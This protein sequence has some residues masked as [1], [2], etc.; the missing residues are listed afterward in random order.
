MENELDDFEV[1]RERPQFLKILC[2]LTFIGSGW[3]ICSGLFSYFNADNSA[4]IMVEVKIK[5]STNV[6][7]DSSRKHKPPVFVQEILRNAQKALTPDNLRKISISKILTG[8]FCLSGALLMWNL[9]RQG[10]YLYILGVAIEIF[11]PFYLFG[12]NSYVI[13][14]SIFIA[15]FGVLFVIFYGMNIKSMK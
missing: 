2:I 11:T 12:N 10:Y 5:D 7:G 9:R 14:S 4:K 6:R 3:G 13:L 15:F 1:V 8:L